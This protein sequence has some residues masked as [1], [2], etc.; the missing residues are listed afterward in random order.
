MCLAEGAGSAL[1]QE[2]Q[3][4]LRRVLVLVLVLE[5]VPARGSKPGQVAVGESRLADK[6]SVR[7][8][9]PCEGA[10]NRVV[11][12]T[13]SIR[14]HPAVPS[15]PARHKENCHVGPSYV[16]VGELVQSIQAPL[17]PVAVGKGENRIGGSDFLTAPFADPAACSTLEMGYNLDW[18]EDSWAHSGGGWDPPVLTAI[19]NNGGSDA[20]GGP[21]TS[22]H[23]GSPQFRE[24]M[25][26]V[27]VDGMIALE[28]D[29]HCGCEWCPGVRT[30]A[31]VM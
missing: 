12:D 4:A 29:E 2:L 16:G 17:P 14:V 13:E 25:A 6:H 26:V 11:V 10:H 7:L 15:P 23:L 22:L 19:D 28:S 24:P 9:D 27:A 30:G 3:L 21:P 1:E 31:E 18:E 20:P 8:A 5:L